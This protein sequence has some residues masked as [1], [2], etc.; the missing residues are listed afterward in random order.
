[1]VGDLHF[2]TVLL[3]FN[4]RQKQQAQLATPQKDPAALRVAAG[5][6]SLSR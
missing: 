5:M 1:M 4:A 6:K 2:S 3:G